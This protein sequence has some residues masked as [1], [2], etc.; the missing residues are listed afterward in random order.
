MTDKKLSYKE[1][2]AKAV[3]AQSAVKEAAKKA[4]ELNKLSP[5]SKA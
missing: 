4:G 3:K 5:P 1:A 2:I